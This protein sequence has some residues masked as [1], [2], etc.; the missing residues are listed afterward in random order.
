MKKIALITGATSGIGEATAR[1]LANNNF[2]LILTG[3]REERL[4]A[5]QK[6]LSP[7]TD[8]SIFNFDVSKRKDVEEVFKSI[9]SKF[10]KIDVLVNNAGNAHGLEP[11]QEG[12]LDD[13]DAMIDINFKGL[14]Y[15]TKQAFPLLAKS[16]NAHVV[17]ISSIAGKEVYANGNVYCA[18]KHAVDALSK[19]MRIDFLK[20][21]IKVTNIAPG[22]VETEFSM[23]RFKNDTERAKKVYEGVDPLTAHDIAETIFF[24]LNRPQNVQI[25]DI[26]ILASAQ[27]A[28]TIVKRKS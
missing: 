14:L 4:M 12:N 17:N 20:N 23:V 5:L 26:T 27:A 13:W 15:V 28:A 16:E 7:L 24:A 18:S 6:E 2:E 25:A 1:L 9:Y 10:S 3:R 8:I 22:M 11:L 21:D 19:A